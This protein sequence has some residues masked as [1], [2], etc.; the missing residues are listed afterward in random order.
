MSSTSE[1][2]PNRLE[3]FTKNW[4]DFVLKYRW[5]VLLATLMIAMG[6]GYGG[7]FIA[8][9]GDYHAF[10][11][12]SNPQLQAFDA[13]QEKYTKDDNVLIMI[14][15]KQGELFTKENLI[16]L[17]SLTDSAWQT[18]F[19]TRVD[20][21]TNFQH[22]YAEQ[23]DL[24]V[25]DLVDDPDHLNADEVEKIKHIALKEPLLV[26]RLIDPDGKVT[27]IN[28]TVKLPG[29][30]P[31]ENAQVASFVRQITTAFEEQHPNMETYLSGM[32][33]LNGAFFEAS[34]A[35]MGTLMP[36]MFLVIILAIGITTRSVTAT[37]TTLVIIMLS[38]MAA[39]GAG[40]W[41][42]IKLTPPSAAAPTIIMTLAIADS[43]HVLISV[44]QKMREGFTKTE[45]IRESLRLNFMPVFITS[46]TTIIGFLSMNFSEVPPF[47]DL[48]N[49]TS[50]GMAAAFL[51]SVTTLPA[52]LSLLP[53]RVNVREASAPRRLGLTDRLAEFVVARHKPILYMSTLAILG[54]VFLAMQNNLND[55]FV[56]YF[57]KK[58]AFRTDTDAISEKLTGIYN[59]EFSVGAGEEGGV[60]NPDYLAYLSDFETWLYEQPEVIHVNS[61]VET[62]KRVNKSMHGDSLQYYQVPANREEAA[63]YLLLY[64][65]SL[66]FGLDLN[67]QINV[68]K[69]ETRVT[70]TVENLS[71]NKMIAFSEEAENWLEGNTPESMHAT[72]VSPT[73]MFSHLSKAQV[74]SAIRGTLAAIVLISFVLMLAL[75][76]FNFG[77]LSLIPNIAPV[78]VGFGLWALGPATINV[79]I[80]VVFGMTLGIIVDDTVHFLSK[81]LRAIRE[82]GKSPADAVRYA[83][84]TVGRALIVTTIVL[85]AGFLVLAQS[86]FGMN[87]GMAQVTILVIVM[88]L[89]I[90]FLLLPA[91]LLLFGQSPNRTLNNDLALKPV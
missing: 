25:E 68:D 66:P 84:Q 21:I 78:A 14:E 86:S 62:S 39:M 23:D 46:L 85:T 48:G 28:I 24:Y 81:Y 63:Q 31:A 47:H 79:G 43:I 34:M 2:K 42:G 74:N 38:L 36:L 52:M 18:P 90:D 88:A 70:V 69:S 4:T 27:A 26:H 75:R 91:M 56:E 22:T 76:S 9:D 33:M 64:E 49:L 73:V 53:I 44:L 67:N 40:G 11:K 50:V 12:K 72:G 17:K 8:F 3:Q 61:Y 59:V 65:L 13:L 55:E 89:I 1:N 30:D 35:D 37:F 77:A 87:A 32:I 71:S 60:N 20:A 82:Q 83:F 19:S 6:L 7:Q 80:S 54:F 29:K 10:F 41:M 45:A 51:F 5:P 58:V 15:P 16:A 57:D